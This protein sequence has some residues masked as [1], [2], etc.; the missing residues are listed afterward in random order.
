MVKITKK[1]FKEC[2]VDSGG[3]ITTIANRLGVTRKSVYEYIEKNPELKEI[4]H[5]EVEK[6]LDLAERSLF[7]QVADKD[8]GATKYL[9]STKGKNR[10]YVEKQEIEHSGNQFSVN[11]N[12]PKEVKELLNASKLQSDQ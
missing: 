3:V 6:I 8:L 4:L 12:I 1:R 9:L 5:H 10:G 7:S 2:T 11:V